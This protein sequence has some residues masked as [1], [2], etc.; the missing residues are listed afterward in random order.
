MSSVGKDRS[1]CRGR[2][3]VPQQH[4]RLVHA[5]CLTNSMVLV[6]SS[7][8]R[9]RHKDFAWPPSAP[10][11]IVSTF[12]LVAQRGNHRMTPASLAEDVDREGREA[13]STAEDHARVGLADAATSRSVAM[14]ASR[15]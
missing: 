6:V 7:K 3:G 15:S 1:C 9:R 2:C 12:L 11:S 14:M 8:L 5:Q 10:G 4:I 13:V